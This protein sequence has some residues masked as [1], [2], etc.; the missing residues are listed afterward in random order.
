MPILDSKTK[1]RQPSGQPPEKGA[2]STSATDVG[3][4]AASRLG[5]GLNALLGSRAKRALGIVTYHRV[6]PVVPG[7]P[8]PLHNVTPESFREQITG[9]LRRGFTAWPLQRVIEFSNENRFLPP[10]TFVVTFDDGYESVFSGAWPVLRELRVPATI[11]LNT[12]FVDSDYPFPCDA[13]GLRY[14]GF[15]PPNTYRPLR[16]C[17]CQE[18]LDS[19]LIE[20]GAHT[21]THQDFRDRPDDFHEDMLENLRELHNRL[22]VVRPTFAFPYGTA[23][24]GFTGGELLTIARQLDL[25]CALSTESVLV[26]PGS[27]P[28]GWGRFNSFPWDTSATLAAKLSGWYSWA[29]KL[30]QRL[31]GQNA[32]TTAAPLPQEALV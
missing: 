6:A 21:H 26:I 24:A 11:F 17:Q 20:F 5:V 12:A 1:E 13:W 32:P 18:M 15:A 2:F 9:L 3:M 31:A 8:K 22:G 4:R 25:Q 30:K 19:G 23:H 16:D 14:E 27:D 7:L 10:R 28:F 29:P